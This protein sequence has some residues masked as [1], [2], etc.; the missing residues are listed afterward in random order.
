MIDPRRLAQAFCAT[1][2]AALAAAGPAL[3]QSNIT[4]GQAKSTGQTSSGSP[5]KSDGESD[6]DLGGWPPY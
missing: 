3:A 5:G 2:V 1:A 4:S 6:P